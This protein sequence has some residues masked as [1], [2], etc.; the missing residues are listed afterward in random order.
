MDGSY[1]AKGNAVFRHPLR[2]ATGTS[3]GFCVCELAPGVNDDGAREIA[4]ALNM[5]DASAAM[6]TA[7]KSLTDGD[8]EYVGNQIRITC[9][10]HGDAIMR[11]W[12]AREAVQAAGG[13]T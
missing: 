4:K 5:A 3:M 8:A 9:D 1:Y 11:M 6:L 10:D 12:K 7:L 13:R 2:R